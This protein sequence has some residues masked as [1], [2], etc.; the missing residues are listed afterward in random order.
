MKRCI[1]GSIVALFAGLCVCL[2]TCGVSHINAS[3]SSMIED[4]P[5]VCQ[6]ERLD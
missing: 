5:Y 4:V 2:Q 1:S 6:K 3:G